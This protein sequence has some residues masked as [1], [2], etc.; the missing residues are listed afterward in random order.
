[1]KEIQ[2]REHVYMVFGSPRRWRDG[3]LQRPLSD[4]GVWEESPEHNDF[5]DGYIFPIDPLTGEFVCAPKK[6]RPYDLT[7]GQMV[8]AIKEDEQYEHDG[9]QD[10]WDDNRARMCGS[11]ITCLNC[12]RVS[13]LPLTL[14]TLKLKWR[15]VED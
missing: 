11:S 12:G 6:E 10:Y 14:D 4:E 2:E 13:P 15:K 1:M 3:Q 7:A 8:D 9:D 5:M